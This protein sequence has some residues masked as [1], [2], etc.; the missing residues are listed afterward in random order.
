MQFNK[1]F[2]KKIKWCIVKYIIKHGKHKCNTWSSDSMKI[3]TE[4]KGNKTTLINI[5]IF[6]PDAGFM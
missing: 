3:F 2:H 1:K 4:N 6:T 5:N